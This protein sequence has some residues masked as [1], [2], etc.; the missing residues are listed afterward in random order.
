M[1]E[2]ID[3]IVSVS[4]DGI[5]SYTVPQK[6]ATYDLVL[7]QNELIVAENK[8]DEAQIAADQ[9]LGAYNA[10]KVIYDD[11]KAKQVLAMDAQVAAEVN[12]V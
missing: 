7:L 4:A 6:T 2:T 1:P 10:L 12:P 9:A 8:K 3:Q 11:A 5:I